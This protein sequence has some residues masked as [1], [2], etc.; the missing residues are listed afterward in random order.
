MNQHTAESIL[1]ELSK[2]KSIGGKPYSFGHVEH[3]ARL[4]SIIAKECG[5]DPQRAYIFGLLHDVGRFF[6]MDDKGGMIVNDKHRHPIEGYLYLKRLEYNEEARICITHAFI[7]RKNIYAHLYTDIENGMINEVLEQEYNQY[8]LLIQ[9]ADEMSVMN[10][11][12][13]LESRLAREALENGYDH[14]AWERFEY[15]HEIKRMFDKLAK[16]DIYSFIMHDI[17]FA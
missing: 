10:G 2:G 6:V 15:L 16:V 7:R 14:D 13:T 4:A 9:L 1:Y 12:C 8:D 11:W 5:L 3:V 17:L